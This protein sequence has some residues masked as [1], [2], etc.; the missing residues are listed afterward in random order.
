MKRERK[1]SAIIYIKQKI[2]E[3]AADGYEAIVASIM[4]KGST[5]VV[6]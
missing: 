4:R 5:L 6:D 2:I 3:Q 1:G